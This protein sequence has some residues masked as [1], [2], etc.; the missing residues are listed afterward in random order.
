MAAMA[1]VLFLAEW[2]AR[3]PFFKALN[4]ALIRVVNHVEDMPG[5]ILTTRNRG[6]PGVLRGRC[7][8]P[9]PIIA[10]LPEPRMGCAVPRRLVIPDVNHG[11]DHVPLM[12]GFEF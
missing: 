12:A 9:W 11:S 4:P 1:T 8:N 6:Y 10:C 3:I 2:A 7:E 5:V